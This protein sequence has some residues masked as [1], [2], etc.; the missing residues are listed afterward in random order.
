MNSE[1]K[2]LATMLLGQY[3]KG[4]QIT[5]QNEVSDGLIMAIKDRVDLVAEIRKQLAQNIGVELMKKSRI[6]WTDSMNSYGKTYRADAWIFTPEEIAEL[7][8][9]CYEAGLRSQE[10]NL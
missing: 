3:A 5:V 4:G 9:N 8:I 1:Q 6:Q 2:R 7:V 10:V